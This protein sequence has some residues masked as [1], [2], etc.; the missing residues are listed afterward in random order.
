METSWKSLL[1][2]RRDNTTHE[3]LID[4]DDWV[5]LKDFPI[6]VAPHGTTFRAFTRDA[7][8]KQWYLH[9]A[10]LNASDGVEVDHKNGNGLDC[11]KRNLILCTHAENVQNVLQVKAKS[12]ERGVYHIKSN[13][14]Y[15]AGVQLNK[16]KYHLGQFDTIEEAS[17]VVKE[18][19]RLHMPF[20]KDARDE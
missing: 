11:R 14:K 15:Q 20:S 16:I 7:D 1:I 8:G 3:V 18:F 9:R 17:T 10:I 13:N 6:C 19:R 2:T 4:L 5:W 12:G